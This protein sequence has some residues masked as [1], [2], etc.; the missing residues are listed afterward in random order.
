MVVERVIGNQPSVGIKHTVVF[1]VPK[2]AS[3]FAGFNLM[4]AELSKTDPKNPGIRMF[5]MLLAVEP[6]AAAPQEVAPAGGSVAS[7]T[8]PTGEAVAD[9]SAASPTG[10]KGAAVAASSSASA[11]EPNGAAVADISPPFASTPAP[12]AAGDNLFNQS[13][14][15]RQA[16]ANANP[17][18]PKMKGNKS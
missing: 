5:E 7:A 15:K 4:V 11:T 13:A 17:P 14:R 16:Q 2:D 10:P 6:K 8:E 3:M 9:S 12:Q 18:S 1:P